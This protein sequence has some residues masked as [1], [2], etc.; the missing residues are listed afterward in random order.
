MRELLKDKKQW[1]FTCILTIIF[2]AFS[3]GVSKDIV[4]NTEAKNINFYHFILIS[5]AIIIFIISFYL[6]RFVR[7]IITGDVFCKKFLKHFLIYLG[8]MMI[9]LMLIWPGYWVWDEMFVIYEVQA[10]S[11]FTWQSIITQLVFAYSLLIIPS[12]VGITII[13]MIIISLIVAFLNT[14]VELK[15][16]KKLYNIIIYI[17]FLLPAILINNLYVLRLQLYTYFLLL[18]FVTLIFDYLDKRQIGKEKL[19]LLYLLSAVLILWRSEGMIFIFFIPILMAVTYKNL[20]K[21]YIVGL[22]L[23]VNICTYIGYSKIVPSN[24]KY[25]LVVFINPLSVMLQDDL[26]G[27]NIQEDLEKINQVFNI[28][29]IKENPNYNDIE[30]YWKYS[31]TLFQE[32]YQEHKGEFYKAYADILINNPISFLNARFKTFFATNGMNTEYREL[33]NFTDYYS[34][35][36]STNASIELF[37]SKFEIMN[38]INKELKNEIEMFLLGAGKYE[39]TLIRPVFWNAIPIMIGIFIIMI[40]S[41]IKKDFIFSILS[42]SLL[43]KTAV[44]FLTAP[45]SYFM[46]YLPEYICGIV[47]IVLYIF[48]NFRKEKIKW[49]KS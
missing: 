9:F 38:P 6:V 20:R 39:N 2:L 40:I 37:L 21:V 24:D 8:L 49:Q 42:L 34:K 23:L 11:V 33:G 1:I 28:E 14:K 45:A 29:L 7:K 44:V 32:N 36:N 12:P 4:F 48:I 31:D 22:M 3:M 17:V 30:S 35:E 43:A 18:L 25:S 27:E 19:L 15:F 41:A 10:S 46:Y 5:F 47:L 16:G 26:K 13:Q